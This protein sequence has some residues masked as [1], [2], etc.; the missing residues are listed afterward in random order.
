LFCL[1]LSACGADAPSKGQETVEPPFSFANWPM[2]N[3]ANS[4]LPNEQSYEVLGAGEEQTVLDR[5]TGLEWQRSLDDRAFTWSAAGALCEQLRYANFEDWRLPTRIELVSLLDL[6]RTN[7][8]LELAAFPSGSS[9]WFWTA[10]PDATDAARAWYVYFYFGYPDVDDRSVENRVRCVRGGAVPLGSA[11][12]EITPNWLRDART[13]L[14][15]QREVP[16]RTFAVAEA[17]DYCATLQLDE[18]TEFRLPTMKELQ[19]LVDE[20]RARPALDPEAFP[21]TPSESFWS[22]SAWSG[23]TDLNWYVRFDSGSALYELSTELFRVR[24]VR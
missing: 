24:C 21:D 6:S 7:P 13:G 1:A 14:V 20:Q 17:A 8:A 18:E 12:Y 19:T 4:G 9:Q 22:S 23:T 3:S 2:P 11:H 15:W 10:S 5:V 16:T